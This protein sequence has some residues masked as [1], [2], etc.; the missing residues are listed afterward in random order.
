MSISTKAKHAARLKRHHRL[1]KK[2]R[3]EATRP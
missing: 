3:G 1:R 2:I